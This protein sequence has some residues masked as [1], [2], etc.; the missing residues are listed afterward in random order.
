MKILSI[1]LKNLASLAGEHF[2]DFE[3]D[4]LANA[5]LIAV[6]GKTGAGKSTILDAMCLALFNKIPRLKESDG[7]LLDV[8]GSELLTNSPL[9]VLRRGTGHGFA[10]LCFVAQ[11]QKHYQ[12][13][14]EIK[15][16]RENASG[17]LQ[18][19]Q[20]SLKC[21]T[22]GVVVADKTKAVE[23]HI[24]QITQLSFEQFTR[25]VLLAQSE[26][27]A[28]LKARDTER[29]ELLEY[30]TNSSIFAKIG[31]L[32]FEKTR[33][34]T[35]Q[36]KQ[37]ENV[38]GHIEIRSDE[39]VAELQ[40]QFQQLQQQVQQ[41][42]NERNQL[43][44]QQQWFE[45]QQKL[46]SE[47]IFK[48][49]QHETQLNAHA[50][51]ATDRQ[52]LEQLDIFSEIRPVAFQQQQ[53]QKT[54]QQLEPQLQQKQQD[55]S[56]F[57][58]AFEQEKVRYTQAE[59]ALQQFQNFELQHQ[60]ELNQVRKYVQER[61]YIA[62]DYKKTKSRLAHVETQQQPLLQ[63][64]QQLEQ[65]I[66]NLSTQQAT[67]IEQ[68]QHSGHFSV[69]DK[70]LHAHVQQ[71]EQF[72]QH[73]QKVENT[74]GNIQ[75]AQVKLEQDKNL[76]AQLIT[77]FGS[78]QQ[79]ESRLEQ[80]QAQKEQLLTQLNQLDVIQQKLQ[81][82]FQLK[83]EASALK[84][85]L[86]ALQHQSQ[87]LEQNT[88]K[89]ES[90]F[91]AAK[92]E[93]EKLQHILQQQRLL[94]A[95]N[96]E[97]LRA[98]LKQGEACLV[99]G[100]TE[101]P[102]RDDESPVSKALFALQQQQEQ[103]ALQ[104]E[105]QC[106]QQWQHTQQQFT[107]L[108]SEQKQQQNALQQAQN[109]LNTQQQELQ[110]YLAQTQ[111]QLDLNVAQPELEV[112]LQGL[113]TQSTQTKQQ[114]EQELHQLSQAS[115]QQLHLNQSIQNTAYQ[116][117][118]V[119]QLQQQIQHIVDC[120]EINE[121]TL[122]LEQPLAHSQQIVQRLKQRL[123]QLDHADGLSKQQQHST[124]QLNLFISNLNGLNTQHAELTE[125][126]QD[127]AKKGQQNSESANQ[128]IQAMAGSTELK[129]NEWF[130]QHDQQRQ[131][132]QHQYQQLKQNFELARQNFEQ[133]KNELEQL[134]AQHQHNQHALTQC[135]NEINAWLTQHTQFEELQLSQLLAISSTQE[136]QIRL[137]LQ[138]A[139]RVLSEAA[140]A[141][142]TAQQQLNEHQ[143]QQ[144]EI[145]QEQLSELIQL[146]QDKLQ[147]QLEQRDQYKVQ[148]ELHQQNL[149]KQKQFAEQ[150]QQI[151]QQEHRWNK[152]SSLI[153][154]SKGKDFR[155]LA[156][157]YNLDIL[158][159]YANQ[160]L[161]MLSQRYTLKRLDN[162]L[163]LAIIDHDMDGEI[164]SVAS[165]SGGE[166]FLTALAISLAIANMASGSMKIESLFIDEG[167]GTLDASSLH[168]VMN[169][170]DQLQSQGRK[171]ILI[172]HIQEMHERIPVQIQ[173]QPVG[174]GSS[175]IEVVG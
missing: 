158:L 144:P 137:T 56:R 111:I 116:L 58:S 159:E 163:S 74:L 132:V 161:A 96:V 98:E 31:Q 52:L 17:K 160:Q 127:I 174:S 50:G 1:R 6:V 68:L 165:L 63:Q 143:Q 124:Q 48:Q 97:H 54:L 73:Y 81:H 16:A 169:A 82:H 19:V 118:N 28:F 13:R 27:T 24:Q 66:Q 142:K 38:L 115:K 87:Q 62:E 103:Q 122:W 18:S 93:R 140:Y 133:H 167:F 153:G 77:Q 70:G 92:N 105:Q 157:Q 22:D 154:D 61:D 175:R 102:Y 36:R 20:R 148:L 34:I 78:P 147:Q 72:I 146:N 85:T 35:N 29:G 47:V 173:V 57:T 40:A 145:Q 33:E 79:I 121:K 141:L 109:K 4:P 135:N 162:S 75:Q 23:S 172:S 164:R 46:K 14:W 15:R 149:A 5:G 76:I 83:N 171:V 113:S 71:L 45:Q 7:K 25:A 136:Q 42:E 156:Q 131:Q 101:H 21:L 60:D 117:E 107:Q 49:Q 100:S 65:H 64:Q 152:I 2:I 10:E 8:D 11:D 139:E 123:Q 130:H 170:L 128:L 108:Q 53:I 80:K 51:L 84:Q 44:Q 32:A 43:K 88:Q 125:Q 126:L 9:T 39:E 129:A 120:L 12:A 104:Q 26:V 59:T 41:L 110:H 30:L 99:C 89:A 168:M 106:F 37:L 55:F 134:K 138:N 112:Y 3:C 94:H 67:C 95:E 91:Q 166:S 151:Q 69:L 86:G 119:Q 150:I 155:D 114:L 90:E